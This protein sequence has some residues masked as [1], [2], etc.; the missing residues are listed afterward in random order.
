M[1]KY[2]KLLLLTCCIS[3]TACATQIKAAKT[4]NPPPIEKLSAFNQF[5]L[6]S[7][8][9]APAYANDGANLKA[10]AK[11]QEYFDERVRPLTSKWSNSGTKSTRTLVIEPQI[12]Q[13][14]FIGIG[15]RV[16][17][18][19]LAGSSAVLLKVKYF[20]KATGRIIAEPE[21]FQRAAAMSGALTMGGQDNAMLARIVTLAADYT[22]RNYSLAV[23]GETG[24]SPDDASN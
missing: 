5:E 21:F 20:D 18:G 23:G 3:L 4:T 17:V 22:A 2:I 10:S 12:V 6:R 1:P 14:K 19:P 7:V 8:Q 24:M 13:I 15:A 16:F 11:I 9:L